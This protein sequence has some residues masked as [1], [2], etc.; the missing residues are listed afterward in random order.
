MAIDWSPG[1]D[2]RPGA[3]LSRQQPEDTPQGKLWTFVVRFRSN[4]LEPNEPDLP[5]YVQM[6]ILRE[7]HTE[8]DITTEGRIYTPPVESEDGA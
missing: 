5:C 6:A 2:L 3:Q 8:K 1:E 7:K 4:E